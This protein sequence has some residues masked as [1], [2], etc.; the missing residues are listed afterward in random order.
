MSFKNKS[1][2]ASQKKSA[3]KTNHNAFHWALN[4]GIHIQ[5]FKMT[6]YFCS[7]HQSAA[8]YGLC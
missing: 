5:E 4:S 2:T 6:K 1:V 3:N 8:T 7:E